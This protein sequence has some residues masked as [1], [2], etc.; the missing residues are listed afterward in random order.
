MKQRL[1]QTTL[2]AAIF[3]TM[4]ASAGTF[5][6]DFLDSLKSTA[7]SSI[8]TIADAG[9]KRAAR[10]INGGQHDVV[11]NDLKINNSNEIKGMIDATGDSHVSVGTI[12]ISDATIGNL[13]VDQ[14]LEVSGDITASSEATISLN[15]LLLNSVDVQ[16][17]LEYTGRTSI[18]GNVNA[19][20]STVAVGTVRLGR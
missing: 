3:S 8:S 13:D 12:R 17:K 1:K 10:E 6:Q 4:A 16:G 15:D 19:S 14:Q 18:G 11:I 20:H 9:S 5:D 7:T 2:L